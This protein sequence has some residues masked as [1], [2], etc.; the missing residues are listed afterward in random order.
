MD[1]GRLIKAAN[2]SAKPF[3]GFQD[4]RCGKEVYSW[5]IN[6]N[7]QQGSTTTHFFQCSQCGKISFPG[8]E[9]ELESETKKADDDLKRDLKNMEKKIHLLNQS[10]KDL[11]EQQNLI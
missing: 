4:C 11:S 6:S 5:E 1:S 10:S 9:P 2:E 3:G 8:S 7:S